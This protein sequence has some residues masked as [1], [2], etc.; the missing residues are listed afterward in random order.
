MNSYKN[1]WTFVNIAGKELD[2][3][4][5]NVLNGYVNDFN[6]LGL[7]THDCDSINGFAFF[8]MIFKYLKGNYPSILDDE[9]V[10]EKTFIE[11]IMETSPQMKKNW[12]DLYE[13]YSNSSS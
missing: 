10:V 12:K 8:N 6:S 4:L 3:N 1:G 9:T 13:V 2:T 11:K 5:L 7:V